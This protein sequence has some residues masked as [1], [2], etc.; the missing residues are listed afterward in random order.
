MGPCGHDG[1]VENHDQE[2]QVLKSFDGWEPCGSCQPLERV[3][4]RFDL[5][6][7]LVLGVLFR[8]PHKVHFCSELDYRVEIRRHMA[9]I[10]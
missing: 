2:T 4:Q 9:T 10:V 7:L 6:F 1:S 3:Q 8:L 5:L